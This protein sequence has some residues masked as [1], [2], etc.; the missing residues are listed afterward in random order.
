MSPSSPDS[1]DAFFS[2][3]SG[4]AGWVATLKAALES[5]GVRV[6]IDSEQLR[7]GDLFPGA[8]ARAIGSVHCVVLV[9]SRGALASAW[10]EEEYS[11]ALA[12]RR[13]VVAVLIDDVEPP[14]F[15]KGRTW[16]DCRDQERFA[17]SVDQLV[18]GITGNRVRGADAPTVPVFRE[19]SPAGASADEAAI[20]R[21]LIAR[22]KSDQQRLLRTRLTGGAVGAALGG[23]FFVGS[24]GAPVEGRLLLL[25]VGLSIPSVAGWGV[26]VRALSQLST[27]LEQFEVLCDGL[28]ACRTR[29]HPGCMKLRQHFWDMMVRNA[30]HVGLDPKQLR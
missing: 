14:G 4:D 13:Q 9:L 5:K 19:E 15:L 10:V 8:L 21:N 7:P 6:W 24:G 30:A 23:V 2:Y 27:K 16:V 1:F 20:L 22:R 18:F 25:M 11:L 26:T 12:H 28:E 3:H 29:S 17:A